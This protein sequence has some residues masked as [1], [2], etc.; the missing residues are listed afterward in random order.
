VTDSSGT[1]AGKQ[2]GKPFQKGVSGNPGG[3]PKS[4]RALVLERTDDGAEIVEY[5][6]R[7]MRGRLSLEKDDTDE[8]PSI[9]E[10]TE[11]AQL[12]AKMAGALSSLTLEVGDSLTA[13]TDEQLEKRYQA[14]IAKGTASS[15]GP[16]AQ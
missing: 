13:L 3:R 1:S 10:R 11:A 5:A 8:K 14:L 9:R 16:V 7:V 2:R 15:T 4:F 6:I 12:L